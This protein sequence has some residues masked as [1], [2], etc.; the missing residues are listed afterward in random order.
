ML[1]QSEVVVVVVAQLS[2]IVALVF[3]LVQCVIEHL[4]VIVSSSM[5]PPVE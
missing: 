3:I 5:N 1:H 2:P 4:P